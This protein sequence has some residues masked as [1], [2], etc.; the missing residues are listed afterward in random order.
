MIY[1]KLALIAFI[2]VIL[3]DVSGFIETLQK[4]LK[5]WLKL[6]SLPTLKPFSCS[7]CM[8]HHV[9]VIF[10]LLTHNFNIFTYSTVLLLSALTP[11][12]NLLF[13]KIRERFEWLIDKL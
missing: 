3:V 10:L 7:F 5:R 2:V 12:I 4:G 8:T 11:V 13:W 6:N 1:L 9:S